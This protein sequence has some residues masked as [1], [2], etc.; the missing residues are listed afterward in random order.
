MYR[1]FLFFIGL[2]N[3][4]RNYGSRKQDVIFFDDF[5]ARINTLLCR[6]TM[7][8]LALTCSE[9]EYCHI[10]ASQKRPFSAC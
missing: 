1:P 6:R 7:T 2:Y 4:A 9:C 10:S 5:V 3:A 8:S